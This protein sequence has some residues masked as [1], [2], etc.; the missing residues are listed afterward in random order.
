MK[1][2]ALAALGQLLPLLP[3]AD[4]ATAKPPLLALLA[5]TAKPPAT[6]SGVRVPAQLCAPRL[7]GKPPVHRQRRQQQQ[8]RRPGRA[9]QQ[10]QLQQ[11]NS[12]ENHS[13]SSGSSESSMSSKGVQ[14]PFPS[15]FAQVAAVEQPGSSP[16]GGS[17]SS[18]TTDAVAPPAVPHGTAGGSLSEA[19]PAA[20]TAAAAADGAAAGGVDIAPEGL[21]EENTAIATAAEDEASMPRATLPAS[22]VEDLAVA[23]GI[24]PALLEGD[25][26]SEPPA[27]G[28]TDTAAAAAMENVPSP[29]AAAVADMAGAAGIDASLLDGE[30]EGEAVTAASSSAAAAGANSEGVQQEPQLQEQQQRQRQQEKQQHKGIKTGAVVPAVPST[31]SVH[32]AARGTAAAELPLGCAFHLG[33]V[34]DYTSKGQYRSSSAICRSA[35]SLQLNTQQKCVWRCTDGRGQNNHH[36]CDL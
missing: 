31:P 20:G 28:S 34:S 2:P 12:V 19:V 22:V 32:I 29:A 14:P 8:R 17:S 35:S 7:S 36:W 23:A 27:A 15:P 11:A 9:Q 1:V 25:W 21:V 13:S 5:S 10:Q 3:A 26:D 33:K 30:F 16:N 18:I 6:V 24:D 4:A